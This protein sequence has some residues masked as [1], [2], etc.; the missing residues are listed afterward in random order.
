VAAAA[1]DADHAGMLAGRGRPGV[2]GE[3]PHR[4]VAVD[5]AGVDERLP[6]DAI[7]F[8]VVEHGDVEGQV[9]RLAPEIGGV[10]GSG[11]GGQ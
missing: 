8:S 3:G 5:L 10:E 9:D 2:V 7:R 1:V 11:V 4:F 6:G